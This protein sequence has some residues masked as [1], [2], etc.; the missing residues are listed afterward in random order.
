MFDRR[1]RG[2]YPSSSGP[3]TG[4]PAARRTASPAMTGTTV[5]IA[6]TFDPVGTT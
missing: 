5:R 3:P 4:S 2:R 6:A 1:P